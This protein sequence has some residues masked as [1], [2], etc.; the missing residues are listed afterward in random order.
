VA[1]IHIPCRLVTAIIDLRDTVQS[2]HPTA[3]AR[4]SL[5][6]VAPTLTF[7]LQRFLST[8]RFPDSYFA[9][10]T[11]HPAL[12]TSATY[13]PGQAHRH[14]YTRLLTTSTVSLHLWPFI[15]FDTDLRSRFRLL[16]YS[17]CWY[18]E[19]LRISSRLNPWTYTELSSTSLSGYPP[20]RTK[21][22][23]T[24]GDITRRAT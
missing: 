22:R 23:R 2:T 19:L 13:P 7:L 15:G 5:N 9:D 6:P 10:S 17:A 3:S 20:I 21:S 11:C 12:S 18:V 16:S 4:A 8:S 14:H 1:R 24:H